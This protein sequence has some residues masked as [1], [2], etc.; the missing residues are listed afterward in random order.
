MTKRKL[1]E[2][3]DILYKALRKIENFPV[4]DSYSPEVLE[5]DAEDFYH[6][7]RELFIENRQL[8]SMARNALCQYALI[9]MGEHKGECRNIF[10]TK[11]KDCEYSKWSHQRS[12][13]KINNK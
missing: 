8:T 3:N 2:L 9:C 13:D 10:C 6:V 5:P 1:K 7:S 11:R 4:R 12:A